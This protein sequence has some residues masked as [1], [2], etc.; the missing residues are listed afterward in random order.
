MELLPAGVEEAERLAVVALDE[1]GDVDAAALRRRLRP[2]RLVL[3]LLD[4]V[5]QPPDPPVQL[6]QP[7]RRVLNCLLPDPAAPQRVRFCF[8]AARM[9][10]V[11]GGKLSRGKT[12]VEGESE[13]ERERLTLMARRTAELMET[14]A[15][16]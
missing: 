10:F 15:R 6:R 7:P 9:F 8:R 13:N 11:Q 5:Q 1:V 3:V 2:P 16:Q 12:G 14:M 4:L